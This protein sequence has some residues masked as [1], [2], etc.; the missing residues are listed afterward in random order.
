MK[1][2]T[3]MILMLALILCFENKVLAEQVIKIRVSE[4]HP[5]Y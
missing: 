2:F 5:N 4:F 1:K 3:V